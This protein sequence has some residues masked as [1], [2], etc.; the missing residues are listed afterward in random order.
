MPMRKKLRVLAVIA[1]VMAGGACEPILNDPVRVQVVGNGSALNVAVDRCIGLH[2]TEVEV[3]AVTVHNGIA[4]TDETSVWDYRPTNTA[5]T[6]FQT[7]DHDGLVLVPFTPLAAFP[8][9]D[10]FATYVH[11]EPTSAPRRFADRHSFTRR[12]ELAQ[13]AH[14]L[15]AYM[16]LTSKRC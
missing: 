3:V 2:I 4:S 9:N 11:F 1:A 8:S 15:K 7:T 13:S 14:D 16:S 12:F 10:L 5:Q 6:V